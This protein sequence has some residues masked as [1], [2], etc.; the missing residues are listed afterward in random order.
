MDDASASEKS[1]PSSAASTARPSRPATKWMAAV[2]ALT[3]VVST[4]AAIACHNSGDGRRESSLEAKD[5]TNLL[6][7][8][9]L[10]FSCADIP[11]E[12]EPGQQYIQRLMLDLERAPYPVSAKVCPSLD[13]IEADLKREKMYLTIHSREG[14]NFTAEYEHVYMG[15]LRK[16]SLFRD[17]SA[18]CRRAV[19]VAGPAIETS[20]V[21]A[22]VEYIIRMA[23]WEALIA[24]DV[25]ALAI[26]ALFPKIDFTCSRAAAKL[27]SAKIYIGSEAGNL[28][29]W[30]RTCPEA[31]AL[32]STKRSKAMSAELAKIL[33]S[34]RFCYYRKFYVN[35]EVVNA[36]QT[37]TAANLTR[38]KAAPPPPPKPPLSGDARL[39]L[40]MQQTQAEQAFVNMFEYADDDADSPTDA[41]DE[42]R[43]GVARPA[44]TQHNTE[45]SSCAELV[46]WGHCSALS[47]GR[48]RDAHMFEPW[49]VPV[50][51]ILS[52]EKVKMIACSSRHVLLLSGLGNIYASGENS[53]GALGLGDTV[54][55]AAFSLLPFAPE[56]SATGAVKVVK[57]A[58]GC[59]ALGSHSFALDAEGRLYGW[60]LAHA[61]GLGVIKP[62]LSPTQVTSFPVHP[63]DRA[64]EASIGA[65]AYDDFIPCKDVA[66]GGGFTLAVLRSGRVCSFGVWSHGRL[67]L[68]DVPVTT[69]RRYAGRMSTKA[70][71]YLLRPAIIRSLSGVAAV[72]CGEAHALCLTED[73]AI[74]AWGQNSCGQVG[75]G[76]TPSGFLRDEFSP[77][78]VRPFTNGGIK[79]ATICCGSFHS[80]VIDVVGQVY[81]WGGRGSACL[82]NYESTIIDEWRARTNAIFAASTN[83]SRVMVPHEL[84]AWCGAWARPAKVESVD[85]IRMAQVCAGDLH[86]A[87]L[88]TNGQIYLT[89]TGPAVPPYLPS[90]AYDSDEED[91]GQGRDGSAMQRDERRLK[92]LKEHAIVVTTPRRPCA[93]WISSICTRRNKLIASAGSSILALQD[94]ETV[95][96]SLT[97]KLYRKLLVGGGAAVSN[98]DDDDIDDNISIRSF[99]GSDDA[100]IGSYF[101]QR[102]KADCIIIASGKTLLAHRALLAQ[103]SPELRDMVLSESSTD[104]TEFDTPVQILLPELHADTAKALL[105]FLYT[106]V[107]PRWATTNESTLRTLSRCGKNLRIP[108]LQLLCERFLGVLASAQEGSAEEDAATALDMPP[109]TLSRD[110][111]ALVGDPQFADVR[112]VAEGRTIMAH[113]FILE[114][115]CEYFRA[116]FRS[117]S[118]GA[119]AQAIAHRNTGRVG[120]LVDV[121]VPDTFVG[122]LRFLIYLYTDTLPDGS[123]GALLEDLMS[124]D[125]YDVP[126][127]K[128]LCEAM[129]IPNRYNWLDLLRAADLIGSRNLLYQTTLFLRDNFDLMAQSLESYDDS[130]SEGS[131][132][133]LMSV[134]KTEFPWLLEELMM[135]RK[136]NFMAKPNEALVA[137]V[138][139]SNKQVED[140]GKSPLVPLWAMAVI[141]VMGMGYNQVKNHLTIGWLVPVFNSVCMLGLAVLVYFKFFDQ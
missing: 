96:N 47:S 122:F 128:Q 130:V 110:L 22:Y 111:S 66:C 125:R 109:P 32:P 80:V 123:D 14:Y 30:V 37:D 46:A 57:V 112:F 136:S 17:I 13:A 70:S 34:S 56:P 43:A 3:T 15:R 83:Q 39:F 84:L 4:K 102:G 19:T 52:L 107:L 71:R 87:M 18:I 106:D 59:G 33:A 121:V 93:S 65:T 117:G 86:T 138:L 12:A 100:S 27:L 119:A 54:S 36:L 105:V 38:G 124:A 31:I 101:E 129:L 53:E 60:G 131:Q 120:G 82:G 63:D 137:Y 118:T 89:G 55:R 114:G 127:M 92:R 61:L 141:I 25:A 26:S 49:S 16:A 98:V 20:E 21:G 44:D 135:L 77:V 1:G 72:A 35:K 64:A 28:C 76:V 48:N 90:H 8:K 24:S 5:V 23:T 81:T 116:M 132:S 113:R 91:E 41:A 74:L 73:G 85:D 104:G 6:T 133:T 67:G 139:A 42:G 115:R 108:R 88:A 94:E 50:P 11:L 9:A 2:D 126:D 45:A 78:K 140:K 95:S 10:C 99:G 29:F 97:H 62:L 79:A 40:V 134:V 103:R 51:R 58:A 68:G 69:Q 7:L 75:S